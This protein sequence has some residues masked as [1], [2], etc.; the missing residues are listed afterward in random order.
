MNIKAN[1]KANESIGN[2]ARKLK[3][4]KQKKKQK[5]PLLE[6]VIEKRILPNFENFF[7]MFCPRLS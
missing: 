5:N 3:T 1:M 4:K 7:T 2:C 6:Y